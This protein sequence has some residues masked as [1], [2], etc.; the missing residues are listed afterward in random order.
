[1][2]TSPTGSSGKIIVWDLPT[3]IFHWLLVSGFI[4]AWLSSDDNR[5]LD[6]HVFAGYSFFGLLMFR[7]LWGAVGSHYARFRAFAYD[8]PSAFAYVKALMSGQAGRYLGHNPA[9]SWAIFIMLA[10]GIC[11]ALSGMLVFGGEEGHGPL[12]GWINF[13]IGSAGKDIH[14]LCAW[15]MLLVVIVHVGGV[16]FE[17]VLH[18][19]NL[20]WAMITGKKD[21]G[22]GAPSAST[23]GWV[24]VLLLA[25]VVAGGFTYFR[26]YLTETATQRY[27]PFQGPKLADN[28]TWRKECGECHLAYHPTL[29]PARSWLKMMEQQSEHFGESLGLDAD[30]TKSITDFLVKNAAESGASEPAHKINKSVPKNETPLR[31]TETEYWKH[32]HGEIDEK[33]WKAKKVGGKGNCEACH[34]DAKDGTFEDA[35]MRLPKL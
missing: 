9:G 3:R 25:L 2:A 6:I 30:T 26:G 22:E 35:D 24:G 10:L 34:L 7:F 17:S 4:T 19:D 1:M 32:K 21:G 13:D 8:W 5:Y 15:A 23:H 12:R 18:K 27:R 28:A 16:V 14:E 33:Y 29:L 11:V 20:V 31:V